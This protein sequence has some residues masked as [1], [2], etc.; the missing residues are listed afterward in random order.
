MNMGDKL[1]KVSNQIGK[2]DS[3]FRIDIDEIDKSLV[4]ED[5]NLNVYLENKL[6]NS[7]RYEISRDRFVSQILNFIL[8]QSIKG[9]MEKLQYLIRQPVN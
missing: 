3:I 1:Q 7:I 9:K 6:I 4:Y 8:V 2:P 5:D